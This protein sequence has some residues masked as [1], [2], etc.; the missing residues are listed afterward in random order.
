M[1]LTDPNILAMISFTPSLD[2]KSLFRW[3]NLVS[4]HW[5]IFPIAMNLVTRCNS[6]LYGMLELL[7]IGS[8]T[9]TL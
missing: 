5:F 4:D 9:E 7:E 2:Y 1:I 3:G 8:I 6:L